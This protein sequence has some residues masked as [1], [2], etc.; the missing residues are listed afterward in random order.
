MS[1]LITFDSIGFSNALLISYD[2]PSI[3]M[4]SGEKELC[5]KYLG[6]S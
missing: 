6:Y 5:K 2:V 1:H 3:V 4:V